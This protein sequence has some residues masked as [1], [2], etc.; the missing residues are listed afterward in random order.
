MNSDGIIVNN[1]YFPTSSVRKVKW[2][3]IEFVAMETKL[4]R[5]K[6]WGMGWSRTWWARN[7]FRCLPVPGNGRGGNLV[8][9]LKDQKLKV[10]FTVSD[11]ESAFD[12]I[13]LHE[14]EW[15]Q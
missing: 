2:D 9:K 12:V 6:G 3:E 8:V 14:G 13:H 1:Y 7:I 10:G 5:M 4:I 15:M 11:L